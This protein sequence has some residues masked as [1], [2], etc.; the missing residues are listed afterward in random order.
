MVDQWGMLWHYS[1]YNRC[2]FNWDPSSQ[3]PWRAVDG[4][5]DHVMFN[6]ENTAL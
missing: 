5:Y 3:G 2:I 4:D 6:L 1:D